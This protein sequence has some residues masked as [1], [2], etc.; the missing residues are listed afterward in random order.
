MARK[1]VK[2]AAGYAA[3]PESSLGSHA[4]KPFGET[5]VDGTPAMAPPRS[6]P[7]A[8]A[9]TPA[10]PAPPPAGK[11]SPPSAPKARPRAQPPLMTEAEQMAEVTRNP[12]VEVDVSYER[13]PNTSG[14]P[15][16][17]ATEV[18]TQ[19]TVYAVDSR[20]RCVAVRSAADSKL[21]DD[22]PFLGTRL[23]G[24]QVKG[25]GTV[26]MSYPLPR[27]GS[28]AVFEGRKGK[29]R[30]FSRTSAVERV[31]LRLRVVTITGPDVTPSWEELVA[32]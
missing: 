16:K 31:V 14:E 21:I 6:P 22:H 2:T 3:T 12:I 24:G 1:G 15:L 32:D 28:F 18:W 27:P 9:P 30:R 4:V 13:G 19:N 11:S 17:V 10:P 26:E 8:R 5:A 20:M 7:P 23:V 29:K 25:E